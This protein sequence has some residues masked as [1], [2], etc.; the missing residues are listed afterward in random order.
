MKKFCLGIMLICLLSGCCPLGLDG[1][2]VKYHEDEINEWDANPNIELLSETL[3]N[4]LSD[5][6][7]E[8][9]G[10]RMHE[11]ILD[12]IQYMREEY[13]IYN[14]YCSNPRIYYSAAEDMFIPVIEMG[15][16]LMTTREDETMQQ[17][18]S[19]I[20]YISNR[21]FEAGNYD[22]QILCI[23]IMVN[24]NVYEQQVDYEN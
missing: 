22:R 15:I 10:N 9:A 11:E 19:D 3:R 8:K 16:S 12:I 5:R 21:I 17:I 1:T 14:G 24:G 2:P 13:G 6:R 18:K 23:K 4:T 7:A 20:Y